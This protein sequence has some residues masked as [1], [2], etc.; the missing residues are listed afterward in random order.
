MIDYSWINRDRNEDSFVI[1]ANRIIYKYRAK[2]LAFDEVQ[3]EL[4]QGRLDERLIGLPFGYLT[5]VEY[6]E[7]AKAIKLYYNKDSED[8]ITVNDNEKRKEIFDAIYKECDCMYEVKQPNFFKR[9]KRPL[10]A[11]GVVL[12][13]FLLVVMLIKA[14]QEGTSF[15]G[16]GL[17]A[18]L[19]Y[20]A[21]FGLV[22]NSLG[23]GIA[24]FLI[25][26]K[27]YSDNLKYNEDVHEL[28]FR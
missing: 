9:T 4:S 6:R 18:F 14:K 11:F 20:F 16:T 24:L 22:R 2:D 25:G 3:Y 13:A 28:K 1:I 17:I 27:V 19:I 10:I 12:G 21:E 15:E 23:F 26:L 5:K 7:G 8:R